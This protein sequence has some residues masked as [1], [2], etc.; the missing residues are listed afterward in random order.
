MPVEFDSIRDEHTAVRESAGIF[1]VSHMSEIR[2]S[3]PDAT[4]LMQRLTSNDVTRL[5]PGDSQYSMITDDEGTILDDTVVYRLPVDDE[6]KPDLTVMMERPATG[7]LVCA[8]CFHHVLEL[9]HVARPVV[10]GQQVHGL[11]GDRLRGF[12]A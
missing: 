5:D 6:R 12:G 7:S 4:A 11:G 1:D 2:V 9:S 8:S 3:G 10:A